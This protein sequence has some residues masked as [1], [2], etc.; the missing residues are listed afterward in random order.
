MND[1]QNQPAAMP[2][3]TRPCVLAYDDKRVGD[4]FGWSGVWEDEDGNP[5]VV[6]GHRHATE[7]SALSC[8]SRMRDR[9]LKRGLDAR[10]KENVTND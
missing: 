6:C 1:K 2:F 5:L 3:A 7:K 10:A 4:I 8:I 9:V